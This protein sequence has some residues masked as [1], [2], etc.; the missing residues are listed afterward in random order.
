MARK[1]MS[2]DEWDKKAKQESAK[3]GGGGG[4]GGLFL[5]WKKNGH[6]VG[7]IHEFG[8]DMRDIHAS[9]LPTKIEKDGKTK[10][11]NRRYLSSGPDTD[12]VCL[13]TKFAQMKM[14]EGLDSDL[15][16]LEG[17]TKS[18]N[19]DLE[20]LSQVLQDDKETR[21]FKKDL[22]VKGEYVIPFVLPS[23]IRDSENP[24]HILTETATT[25]EKILDV[26]KEQ[27][28]KGNDFRKDPWPLLLT[29]DADAQPADKYKAY[30]ADEYDGDEDYWNDEL[31][32]DK[33]TRKVLSRSLEE[34]GIKIDP[35]L[36]PLPPGDIMAQLETA[37]VCDEIEFDEFKEYV[38]E[39]SEGGDSE[40]DADKKKSAKKNKKSEKKGG[41]GKSKPDPEEDKDNDGDDGDGG[42]GDG[43]DGDEDE[44]NMKF[45]KEGEKGKC[46]SCGEK[47]KFGK[48][49][50]CP[51]CKKTRCLD[52]KD[53]EKVNKHDQCEGCVYQYTDD[54]D[55]AF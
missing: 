28:A 14:E 55:V 13:L 12:P 24:A 9:S 44:K 2:I 23:S 49:G 54:D 19:W 51:K 4:G 36:D 35:H 37:W 29:Y 8:V 42:D 30:R 46:G 52:C 43:D 3:R 18:G 16:V 22:A 33:K 1:G 41:R 15:R 53:F 11:V 21:D 40:E 10:T 6:V 45:T 27:M 50:V 17:K 26:V 48:W 25:G 34:L 39:A 47:V 38:N 32:L 20:D 7:Y 5:N 31:K